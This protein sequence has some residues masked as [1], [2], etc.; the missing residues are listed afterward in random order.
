MIDNNYIKDFIAE[1]MSIS[2]SN[3]V[4]YQNL[5]GAVTKDILIR[6]TCFDYDNCIYF[7][8]KE[9]DEEKIKFAFRCNCTKDIMAN[10]G[11]EVLDELYKEN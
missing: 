11:Q 2:P 7:L 8:S 5:K 6:E 9:M 3:P 10:G 4:M 1:M